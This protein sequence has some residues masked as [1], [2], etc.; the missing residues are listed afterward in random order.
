MVSVSRKVF[1]TLV[2]FVS[3]V[4][5]VIV[6]VPAGQ[7]LAVDREKFAKKVTEKIEKNEKIAILSLNKDFEKIIDI[8]LNS[9]PEKI[10]EKESKVFIDACII[11]NKDSHK[12]IIIGKSGSMLKKINGSAAREIKNLTGK[13][14][15]LSLYVRVEEDWLNKDKKLFDFIIRH[16]CKLMPVFY[17]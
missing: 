14:V 4:V 10:K 15:F 5:T 12:G 6:A 1:V 2:P 3:T 13:K 8:S 7:A 16:R 9:L 17:K 11:C